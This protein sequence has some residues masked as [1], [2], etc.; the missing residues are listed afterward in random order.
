M[1][2]FWREI[3]R[4]KPKGGRSP[5]SSAVPNPPAI[6]LDKA[7]NVYI[8]EENGTASPQV[9]KFT[10]AGTKSTFATGIS[11][12]GLRF[13]ANGNLFVADSISQSIVKLTPFGARSTFAAVPNITDLIFDRAGNL[14]AADDGA[15]GSAGDGHGAIYKF[16]SNGTKTTFASGLYRPR[17]LAF[18]FSDNLFVSAY[19]GICFACTG[20]NSIILKFMPDGTKS[21]FASGFYGIDGLICDAAGN[22]FAGARSETN[23]NLLKILPSGSASIFAASTVADGLAFEP[24]HGVPLNI[25]TRMRVQTGEN[26]L[27]AGF[28]ITG[29]GGKSVVI[30]GI[31]PSLAAAGIQGALQDPILELHYPGGFVNTNDNWKDTQASAIQATGLAPKDDRESAFSYNLAPGTYTVVMKG[32]NNG[33]GIGLVEV[34]D[35]DGSPACQLANISTRGHVG[36]GDDVMIGGFILGGNGARVIVRAIGPSLTQAGIAGALPDTKLSLRDVNGTEI[37]SNDDWQATQKAEIQATGVP[38]T[39]NL[40]SA[41][42]TTLPN[43]NYTAI[44]SSPQGATGVALVEVYNLQ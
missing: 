11:P 39:N 43:G 41:I 42:V 22:V 16:T 1:F 40:E 23:A 28:I 44:V 13:D 5:S 6:A 4:G 32:K 24:P 15:P 21:T 38:P 12:S 7:G 33:T 35:V 27:I 18:D 10:P 26:V 19:A 25:A 17:N 29:T 36:I 37:A 2:G 34:Y 9:S 14:Y 8:G 30:R 31:G 20:P 3:L